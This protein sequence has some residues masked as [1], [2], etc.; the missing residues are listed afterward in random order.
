MN[1]SFF[2]IG[3]N[4]RG[5]HSLGAIDMRSIAPTLAVILGV[6]LPD[7][8]VKSLQLFVLEPFAIPWNP[9]N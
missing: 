5:S 6:S 1:S 3:P 4:I 8:E 2:I 9:G 7:A